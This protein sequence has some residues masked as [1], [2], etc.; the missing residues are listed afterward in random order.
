MKYA[1]LTAIIEIVEPAVA[2]ILR[3]K[4]EAERLAI[5]WGMWRSARAM[6]ANL[7]RAEHCHWSEEG[8]NREMPGGS[9]MDPA[10][11]LFRP[12]NSTS[13]GRR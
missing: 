5:A 2:E 13:A 6:L 7:L 3:E 9:P 8:V 10:E 1:L 4:T 12:S 11:L